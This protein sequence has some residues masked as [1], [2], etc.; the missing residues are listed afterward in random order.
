MLRKKFYNN[1]LDDL[2]WVKLKAHKRAAQEIKK[3]IEKKATTL[4]W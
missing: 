3:W 2:H 4:K 1:K